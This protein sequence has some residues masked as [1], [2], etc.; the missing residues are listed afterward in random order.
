MKIPAAVLELLHADGD[1]NSHVEANGHIF[2]NFML[3][4]EHAKQKKKD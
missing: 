3:M 1:K 4:R 2:A